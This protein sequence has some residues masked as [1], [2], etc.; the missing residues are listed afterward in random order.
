MREECEGRWAWEL[1]RIQCGLLVAAAIAAEPVKGAMQARFSRFWGQF[2][3]MPGRITICYIAGMKVEVRWLIGIGVIL[4]GLILNAQ[5]VHG[6]R[7]DRLGNHVDR[8][9]DAI[10]EHRVEAA[11]DFGEIK[12]SIEYLRTG[13]P[14][15]GE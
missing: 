1:R 15:G 14:P 3:A 6:N 9:E 11:R 13:D 7:M 4:A 5:R 12:S 10:T 8:L 2:R